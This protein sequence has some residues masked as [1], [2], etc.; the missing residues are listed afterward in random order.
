MEKTGLTLDQIKKSWESHKNENCFGC[1]ANILSVTKKGCLD[2]LIE[3]TLRVIEHIEED[4]KGKIEIKD[5]KGL[6]PSKVYI[7]SIKGKFIPESQL[8]KIS[9][10]LLKESDR[11]GLKIMV[12][13]ED[14]DNPILTIKE[15]EESHN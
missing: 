11:L 12:I 4:E 15:V 6:D 10:D 9:S 2:R 13:S 8:I 1:P 7:F 5:I 3:E 14:Q